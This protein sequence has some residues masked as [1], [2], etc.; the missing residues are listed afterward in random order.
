MFE[1]KQVASIEHDFT[2]PRDQFHQLMRIS[3]GIE[4]VLFAST[5]EGRNVDIA[6]S[7]S[8]LVW[9]QA[10]RSPYKMPCRVSMIALRVSST[11][12]G[13]SSGVPNRSHNQLMARPHFRVGQAVKDLIRHTA[14]RSTG[15][16]D[17][18]GVTRSGARNAVCMVI[19]PPSEWPARI[20]RGRFSV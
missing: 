5:H 1:W 12:F 11:H 19:A 4:P 7:A 18:S 16:N 8:R 9:E 13:S 10:Y 3:R 14:H 6:H 20:T 15:N 17:Q 2:C